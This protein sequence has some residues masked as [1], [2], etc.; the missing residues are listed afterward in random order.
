MTG[1]AVEGGAHKPEQINSK[2]M[3]NILAANYLQFQHFDSRA[4]RPIGLW[5]VVEGS[6]GIEFSEE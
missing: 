2:E 4:G 3:Y 1:K 6:T 5:A